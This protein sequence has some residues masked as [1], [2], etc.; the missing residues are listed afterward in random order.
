MFDVFICHASQDKDKVVRPLAKALAAAG[1]TVW[2]DEFSLKLGDSLRRSI[3]RGLAESRFGVVVLSPYFFE[4]KWPQAE[5]DG[6][7]A[8]EITGDKTILPV[9]H[10]IG[11]KEIVRRSPMLADR[12]AARTEDGL[13]R[14]TE[15]I[16]DVLDPDRSHRTRDGVTVSVRPTS[17]RLHTGD[18]S[19]KTPVLICNQSESPIYGVA[20][21]I[22]IDSEGVRSE[23]IEAELDAK[24]T[25]MEGVAADIAVSPDVFGL[26][27]IDSEGHDAVVVFVHTIGPHATRELIVRGTHPVRSSAH[28]DLWSFKTEPPEILEQPSSV[29]FPFELAEDMKIKAIRARLRRKA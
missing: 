19:V 9:W 6:L 24:G 8:K 18:W 7:F 28:I 27:C 10:Q 1:L 22:T 21:K 17:I 15:Q 3:E 4:K 5:L 20:L 13:D 11:H 14:V 16:L 26:D 12:V 25:R 23:S 2:Y 29:A